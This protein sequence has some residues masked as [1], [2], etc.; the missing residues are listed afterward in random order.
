[1][2]HLRAREGPVSAIDSKPRQRAWV[3]GASMNH[4]IVFDA[5]VGWSKQAA[6]VNTYQRDV[7]I[8]AVSPSEYYVAAGCTEDWALVYDVRRMETPTY[9]FKHDGTAGPTHCL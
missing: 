7:N 8:L 3:Y 5:R 4:I 9:I 1:M 6:S 2:G